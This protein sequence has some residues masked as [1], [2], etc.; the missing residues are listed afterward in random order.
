MRYSTFYWRRSCNWKNYLPAFFF[1]YIFFLCI[2]E[3]PDWIIFYSGKLFSI[4]RAQFPSSSVRRLQWRN[5]AE[6]WVLTNQLRNYS[7]IFAHPQHNALSWNPVTLN[8][9]CGFFDHSWCCRT[10]VWWAGPSI[11]CILFLTSTVLVWVGR[12]W[13]PLHLYLPTWNGG[14]DWQISKIPCVPMS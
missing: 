10:I 6:V 8:V 12:S 3:I 13:S 14:S 9:P 4:F 11:V 7:V 2:L 5:F 1:L